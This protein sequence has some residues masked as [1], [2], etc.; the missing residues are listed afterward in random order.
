ML[1]FT[2]DFSIDEEFF[3]VGNATEMMR[4]APAGQGTAGFL[5]RSV[6][7]NL[8]TRRRFRSRA[9]CYCWSPPERSVV[10]C[11]GADAHSDGDGTRFRDGI[12]TTTNRAEKR[13]AE[14]G[15]RWISQISLTLDTSHVMPA[16]GADAAAKMDLLV[17]VKSGVN[18]A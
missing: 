4:F 6:E 10:L 17:G 18:R 16:L 14:A 12:D 1:T 3:V 2:S 9:R 11:I 15:S 13:T 5:L 8:G 7:C